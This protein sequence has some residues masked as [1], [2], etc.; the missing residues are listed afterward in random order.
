M[1][2]TV[3]RFL[4]SFVL[5]ATMVASP[6]AAGTRVIVRTSLGLPG[7]QSVCSLL[8]CKVN[9][10][11][12]DPLNQVFLI[13]SPDLIGVSTFLKL[14]SNVLGIVTAEVDV[15]GDV[16]QSGSAS[17]IPAALNDRA[18]VS[19]YGTSVW[20]GYVDQPATRLVRLAQT[21]AAFHTDGNGVVAVIDT[22][23]DTSHPALAPVLLPGYDFTRNR[24]SADEKGDLQQETAGVVDTNAPAVWVNQ[25][26]AGVVDQETAGVVDTTKYAAFGHGTMV[27]GV[28]HLVA[29]KAYILPLKA[30]KADGSGY[31]SDVIRAIYR[32]VQQNAK[33][34]NMSFS[35]DGSSPELSRAITHANQSNVIAIASAGNDG[36]R[37]SQYPAS[38]ADRVMGVASTTNSDTRSSFS[39]YGPP[40]VWVTAPG[41][42]VVTLY[43][44]GSYAA[45]WGTS[46]SA[47]FASGAAALL[48]DVNLGA[49]VADAASA[50]AHA[51]YINSDLGKGRLDLYQ[52][53][54]AWRQTL[55]IK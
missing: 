17:G 15:R 1:T 52:A 29:P 20:H 36:R 19:Y 30:F 14:I 44:F 25:E 51:K 38:Y 5:L 50:I 47:P 34:I 49:D 21:Q 13:T 6:A 8:G 53:V 12:G 41:E 54:S 10:G 35:F 27:A 43:P 7:L 45:A 18:P 31:S 37:I 22:G 48:L 39:N 4:I 3:R 2:R 46:F 24:D 11:L 33:V 9:Y 55:G 40:L 23:V 42:G 32:A 28:I 16:M 26:T